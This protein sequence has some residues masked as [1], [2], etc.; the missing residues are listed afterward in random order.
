MN[1]PDPK[2]QPE[3]WAEYWALQIEQAQ[4]D[5]FEEI[6]GMPYRRIPYGDGDDDLGDKCRDCFVARSQFHV[7]DCAVERCGKCEEQRISCNC[8]ADDVADGAALH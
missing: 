2:T 8:E 6:E 4:E 7:I 3:A 1:R 5:E